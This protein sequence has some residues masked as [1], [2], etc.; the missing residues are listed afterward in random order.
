[1][2]DE[3]LGNDYDVLTFDNSQEAIKALETCEPDLVIAGLSARRVTDII[4][5]LEQQFG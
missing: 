1:M 4:D 2:V 3:A 5:T